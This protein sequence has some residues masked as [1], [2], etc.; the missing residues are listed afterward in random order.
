M[1]VDVARTIGRS[2]QQRAGRRGGGG[3]RT[4]RGWLVARRT[5]GGGRGRGRGDGRKRRRPG[6]GMRR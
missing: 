2:G 3:A 4:Q 1:L 5:R 6:G